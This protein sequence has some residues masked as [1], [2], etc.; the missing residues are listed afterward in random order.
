MRIFQSIPDVAG[1]PNL[2]S[3]MH[4]EVGGLWLFRMAVLISPKDVVD[5]FIYT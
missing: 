5:L 3:G 1:G 2:L 4:P